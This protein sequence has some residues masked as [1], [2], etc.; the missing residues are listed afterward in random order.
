MKILDVLA[1]ILLV[2][3]GV[4]WFL[5]GIFEFDIVKFLFGS[6]VAIQKIVYVL[7]GLAAFYQIFEWKKI[8]NRWKS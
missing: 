7:V 8:Q 3:G 1:A 4:N 6:F 5:F 2:I